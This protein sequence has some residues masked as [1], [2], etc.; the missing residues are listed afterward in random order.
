[1]TAVVSRVVLEPAAQDLTEAT[2]SYD[3]F[4]SGY[5]L[6]RNAMEWFWDAYAPDH[7]QRSEINSLRDTHA[8][9]AAVAQATAFLRDA[10]GTA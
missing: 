6:S 5:Y 7:E 4:E 3:R 1:M 8:T 10:L 2:A 9:R